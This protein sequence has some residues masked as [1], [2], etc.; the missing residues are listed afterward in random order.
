MA[1]IGANDPMHISEGHFFRLQPNDN[2]LNNFLGL[3]DFCGFMMTI[4]CEKVTNM[5]SV[6]RPSGESAS[7]I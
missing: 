6:S 5:S 7:G 1:V 4:I 2:W 3:S